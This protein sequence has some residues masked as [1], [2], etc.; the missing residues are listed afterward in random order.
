MKTENWKETT[1]EDLIALAAE[2]GNLETAAGNRTVAELEADP[3]YQAQRGAYQGKVSAFLANEEAGRTKGLGIL[4]GR[5]EALTE[6]EN[7]A[8]LLAEEFS[9]R[10]QASS[11]MVEALVEEGP[12]VWEDRWEELGEDLDWGDELD[13]FSLDVEVSAHLEQLF[14]KV[15]ACGVAG[16]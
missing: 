5:Q 7:L 16:I 14:R 11:L 9:E 2:F 1:Y 10:A 3:A 15:A 12:D 6:G 13:D 4:G 8:G